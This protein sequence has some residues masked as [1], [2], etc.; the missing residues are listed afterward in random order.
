MATS[1]KS[2]LIN[3]LFPQAMSGFQNYNQNIK[4]IRDNYLN[5]AMGLVNPANTTGRINN[6]SN[7]ALMNALQSYQQGYAGFDTRANPALAEGFRLGAL[8]DAR[9]ATNQF[10]AQ[11][12]SSDQLLSNYANALQLSEQSLGPDVQLLIQLLAGSQGKSGGGGI[13]GSLAGLA[14]TAAGIKGLLK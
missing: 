3:L 7:N 5:Q 10:A 14:S 1:K 2:Q 8:N 12:L 13:F 9:R 6:F 4:P 11:Q